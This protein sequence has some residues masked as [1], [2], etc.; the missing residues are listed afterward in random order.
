M[1]VYGCLLAFVEPGDPPAAHR[2]VAS[3]HRRSAGRIGWVGFFGFLA[4]GNRV[5]GF[6]LFG[7]VGYQVCLLLLAPMI[8]DLYLRQEARG[9]QAAVAPAR[10]G[11][12]ACAPTASTCGTSRCCSSSWR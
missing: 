3:R 1:I 5:P 8:L 9:L 6:E 10:C 4:L 7:G 2:P 11:G 12:S